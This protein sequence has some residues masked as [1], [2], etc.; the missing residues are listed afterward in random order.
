MPYM[1]NIYEKENNMLILILLQ[2]Q[3]IVIEVHLLSIVQY[4]LN[5][6]IP[7]LM[8]NYLILTIFHSLDSIYPAF[9]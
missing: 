8:E 4:Y 1:E 9:D 3:K 5:I 6:N 7:I 2:L